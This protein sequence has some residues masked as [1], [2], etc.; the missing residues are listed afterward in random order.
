MLKYL[1]TEESVYKH[2]IARLPAEQIRLFI[3]Q[4]EKYDRPV[5][6]CTL[7]LVTVSLFLSKQSLHSYWE[8]AW[9]YYLTINA[10]GSYYRYGPYP[11]LDRY[12]HKSTIYLAIVRYPMRI[13]T[14]TF[15]GSVYV[16]ECLSL[17]FVPGK[18]E[19][20]GTPD[21]EELVFGKATPLITALQTHLYWD[22]TD[23]MMDRIVTV[24]RI[25][26]TAPH[27]EQERDEI[28]VGCS[29]GQKLQFASYSFA[30][31]NDHFFNMDMN[32]RYLTGLF[33]RE[34]IERSL[35]HRAHDGHRI[36]AFTSARARLG[37]VAKKIRIDRSKAAF[38]CPAYFLNVRKFLELLE[39]ELRDD[40][41]TEATFEHYFG[42]QS[43]VLFEDR[44]FASGHLASLG[45]I[46]TEEGKLYGSNMTADTLRQMVDR[47]VPDGPMLYI[48]HVPTWRD[49]IRAFLTTKITYR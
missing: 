34:L 20:F 41:L 32:A 19:P 35:S 9:A 14:P 46:L 31:A 26:G 36:P 28:R 27:Y 48:M 39:R 43:D 45:N 37:S 42:H 49:S 6:T 7:G 21:F 25:C 2:P 12:D 13:E 15:S 29:L 5:A 11:P 4:L 33:R 17:R 18:Y 38:R 30:L 22:S 16:R 1:P 8:S 10:R 3:S 47:E 40:H 23:N 44:S 24:S